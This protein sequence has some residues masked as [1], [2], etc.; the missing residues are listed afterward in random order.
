MA[1]SDHLYKFSF[2]W[3]KSLRRKGDGPSDGGVFEVSNI[4][5]N[6]NNNKLNLPTAH[7]YLPGSSVT[8]LGFFIAD[9]AFS[10]SIRIMKPYSGKNL[11]KK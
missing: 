4:G 9:A 11:T 7:A 1:V 10:L 2:S 6:L 3:Y 5:K 8:M